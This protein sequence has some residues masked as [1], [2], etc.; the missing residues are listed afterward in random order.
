[1]LHVHDLPV[2]KIAQLL[3]FFAN[4][5]MY[6]ICCLSGCGVRA[7]NLLKFLNNRE[8]LFVCLQYPVQLF[9]AWSVVVNLP[10]NG[11]SLSLQNYLI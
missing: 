8:G 7:N 3:I 1:M 4:G 11:V 10:N 6:F 2:V 9:L 5:Y